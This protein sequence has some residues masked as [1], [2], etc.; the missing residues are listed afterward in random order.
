[1]RTYI[2]EKIIIGLS[3]WETKAHGINYGSKS[4]S[5]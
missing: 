1:V 5:R 2:H 3:Q 4:V